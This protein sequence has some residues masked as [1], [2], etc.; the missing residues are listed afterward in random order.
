MRELFGLGEWEGR[1][2]SQGETV[3]DWEKY[4]R[5]RRETLAVAF[6]FYPPC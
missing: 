4:H 6:L 3:R 2:E 1:R 5:K